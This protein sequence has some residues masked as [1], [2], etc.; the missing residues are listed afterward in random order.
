MN[1]IVY[2]NIKERKDRRDHMENML[3]FLNLPFERFEGIKIETTEDIEVSPNFKPQPIKQQIGNLGLYKGHIQIL[4][5]KKNQEGTL[6]ILED[7]VL[8]T[9]AALKKVN[10]I[11]KNTLSDLDWDVAR[12]VFPGFWQNIRKAKMSKGLKKINDSVYKFKTSTGYSRFHDPDKGKMLSGGGHFVL[13]NKKNIQKILNYMHDEYFYAIDA[14]YST[15]QINSYALKFA[16]GEIKQFFGKFGTDIGENPH[17]HY[18]KE[19]VKKINI[20][21]E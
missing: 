11:I 14:I 15:D 7:D 16:D 20:E 6:L 18:T 19:R 8:I 21:Y 5:S 10:Y 12:A 2:I 3:R 4:E 9:K 17:E 13:I 1:D